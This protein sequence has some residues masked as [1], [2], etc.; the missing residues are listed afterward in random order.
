MFEPCPCGRGP[1]YLACCAPVH[2]DLSKAESAERV[3]RARYT[4]YVRGDAGFLRA[5]WAPETRP[6]ALTPEDGRAWIG[7]SVE[8]AETQAPDRATVRF[9]ARYRLDGRV[10]TLRE[11]SRFRRDAGR[12]LYV[13]GD[14]S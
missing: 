5:S 9:S 10:K 6:A 4:A 3:M 1:T 11:T 2:A 8:A 7:L 14:V 12:W 13:D